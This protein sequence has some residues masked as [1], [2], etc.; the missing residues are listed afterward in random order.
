MGDETNPLD[1]IHLKQYLG[2]LVRRGAK[3]CIGIKEKDGKE[4][5]VG[6]RDW[7]LDHLT[8]RKENA[9]RLSKEWIPSNITLPQLLMPLSELIRSGNVGKLKV[10][11]SA[12]V[13]H[14]LGE[15]QLY[16]TVCVQPLGYNITP[17]TGYIP[18]VDYTS[19][20]VFSPPHWVP[21]KQGP[22]HPVQHPTGADSQ[23]VQTLQYHIHVQ[24]TW[25]W[26]T[27]NIHALALS[28]K[29]FH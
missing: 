10:A 17:Y 1:N 14:F 7:M 4:F 16:G 28:I 3:F 29:T 2:Y 6:Q 25:N 5:S 12:F 26:S 15:G 27:D 24:W 23:V 9:R 20:S 22:V 18:L 19:P 8:R 13:N 21:T 11:A